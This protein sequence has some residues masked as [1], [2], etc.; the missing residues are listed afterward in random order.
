[1]APTSYSCY[2]ATL[3]GASATVVKVESYSGRGIP[4]IHIIGL[5]DAAIN[6]SRERMKAATTVS[7]LEWPRSKITISLS[8]ASLR[9]NGAC[10]DMA[11]VLAVLAANGLASGSLLSTTLFLGELGLDGSIRPVS[12]VLPSLQAAKEAGITR[13]VI[14]AAN[15]AEA[16]LFEGMRVFLAHNLREVC[17]FVSGHHLLTEATD[18]PA[19]PPR[20]YPDVRDIIGQRKALEAATIAAAGSHHMFIMGPPG[21]G[22]TMIAQRI[23]GL[24]PALTPDERV[25][26]T[27]IN[28]ISDNPQGIVFYPPF[29]SPHHSISKAG[30]LGGGSGRAKPG[31]ISLAHKGVL[32]LD[33]V[34]EIPASVLD[35]LRL[36]L[37]HKEIKLVRNHRPVHF[38]ADFQLVMAA[39][40]CRC[41]QEICTCTGAERRAYLANLSGPI[42]DRIDIFTTTEKRGSIDHLEGASSTEELAEIVAVARERRHARWGSS[43]TGPVLRREFPATEEA[44]LYLDELLR[45]GKI[46]HRR[47]DKLLCIAWT[48]AD[49]AGVHT[50]TIDHV[51]EAEV[52]N[53]PEF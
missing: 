11:M 17:D 49:L 5:A 21:S 35:S 31:A 28:S 20:S 6:E 3:D 37:E 14:P 41:C 40:P 19:I 4:G 38:P 45:K 24:L 15:A 44:M 27:A 53:D 47:A 13:A 22:K 2:S 51:L 10:F 52:Y 46:S 33:E 29:I 30:L 32:F 26:C 48:L 34:S 43:V 23:Q 7:G 16:S 42:R 50:P 12:G 36:P 1:M 39:N 18:I 9:K 8:P 25:E